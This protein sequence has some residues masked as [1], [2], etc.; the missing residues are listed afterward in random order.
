MCVSFDSTMTNCDTDKCFY[1]L[2]CLQTYFHKI[3]EQN[4]EME[5][6]L[7]LFT[8]FL[9]LALS[10]RCS[11]KNDFPEGFTFGSA[12]SAYQWEGAFD[13][14]GRKPS[15]WDTFLHSR[16]RSNGDITC[17]GYHKYKIMVETG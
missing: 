6:I 11:D 16:N 17:D 5:L 14:D 13:E 1:F 8:T 9:F 2:L 7:S 12:T 4:R 3:M 15:V 10:G